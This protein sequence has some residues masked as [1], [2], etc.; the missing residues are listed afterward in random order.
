MKILIAD[1]DAVSRRY[2]ETTLHKWGYEVIAVPDGAQACKFMEGSDAPSVAILDWIMPEVDGLEVCRRARQSPP[3]AATY[4]IVLTARSGQDS[5]V[6]ALESGA[7]DFVTKPFDLEELRARVQVG[8]RVAT[9]Q[10]KLAERVRQL[11][12]A[13]GKVKQL[14]GLVPICS[15]C[16]KIRNDR[17]YWQQV[18]GYISEH[19]EAQFS[20]GVCPECYARF[21][22]PELEESD[23][24][25]K[26]E[27]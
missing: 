19:S 9:L 17:N 18:E 7:D 1:D 15:Y 22:K 21:V 14:Q 4:L 27:T 12:E 6:R 23:V 20:H 26:T 13:L 2:L 16:K 8:V 3:T 5:T 10:K 11:E 25:K 24:G